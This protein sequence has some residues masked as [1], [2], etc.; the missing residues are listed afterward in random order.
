[1]VAKKEYQ[2]WRSKR[3]EGLGYALA[4]GGRRRGKIEMYE[5]G[6]IFTITGQHLKGTPTSIKDRQK[7]LAK[8]HSRIFGV[9]G[10][11][12]TSQPGLHSEIQKTLGFGDPELIQKAMQGKNG[13]EFS[14]LWAGDWSGYD[15]QSE[16]DFRLCSSLAFWTGKNPSQ[17]DRLF[18]QSGLMRKKWDERRGDK[19]YGEITIQRAIEMAREVYSPRF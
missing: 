16:A 17:M 14:R 2:I 12:R 11:K 7:E 13:E 6:R 9:K 4:S 19:T 5:T 10:N 8:L 1:M 15:S 18:R 3:S